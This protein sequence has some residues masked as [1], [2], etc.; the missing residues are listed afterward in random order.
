MRRVEL[1]AWMSRDDRPV[2]ISYAESWLDWVRLLFA[3]GRWHV[4]GLGR[5]CKFEVLW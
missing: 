5:T 1:P 3:P 4:D 2:R